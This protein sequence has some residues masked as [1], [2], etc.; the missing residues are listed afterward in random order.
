MKFDIP[1]TY[2]FHNKAN[3]DVEV[4]LIRVGIVS[5]NDYDDGVHVSQEVI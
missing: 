2:K 3:V 5:T 1:A 4:D